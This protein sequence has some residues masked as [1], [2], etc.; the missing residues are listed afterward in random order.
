MK[1]TLLIALLTGIF[2]TAAHAQSSVTLYGLID[3]GLTYTSNQK[4]TGST[5]GHSKFG[6]TDASINPDRFGLRGSEDLGG[7]LKAMFALENGF[8]LT[9]GALGQHGLLFGRQAFAGLSSDQL[10]TVTFGRQY[11]SVVDYLAPLAGAGAAKGGVFF[12]HPYDND[13]LQNTMRINNAVKYASPNYNGWRFG[14][15]YGFSN[16]AGGFSD[17]RAYS[18]GTS[19]NNG[20]FRFAASYLQLNNGGSDANLAGATDSL[21]NPAGQVTGS[22][23]TFSAGQQRTFG[24]GFDYAFGPATVGF[25]FTETK[26]ENATGINNTSASPIPLANS[27]LRFDNYE[28]NAVYNV[29]RAFA[30]TGSYTF[31][32]GS[33]SL[34]GASSPK[35][36]QFNLLLDYALSRRTDV[37][38][39]GQFQHVSGGGTVFTADINGLSPSATSSQVAVTAG[40]RTRF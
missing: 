19:Y 36:N 7:G 20:P 17:N 28:V 27:S 16:A 33:S 15:L 6:M 34:A 30:V 39:E 35:W 40:L 10:G 22:D 21:V 18:F 3:T 5:A 26:L 2:A 13:N 24:A 9:N 1:K 25:V 29:T 12:G 4:E 32:D 11:D 23:S 31:T 38:V 37:Y 14:S 8:T